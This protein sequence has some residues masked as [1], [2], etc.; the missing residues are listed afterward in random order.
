MEKLDQVKNE[1]ARL[2]DKL[3]AKREEIA[4]MNKDLDKYATTQ[5]EKLKAIQD[6]LVVVQPVLKAIA[7][8]MEN[9]EDG[10]VMDALAMLVSDGKRY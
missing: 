4:R 1:Q 9:S 7:A 10:D 6:S 5:I 8:L 2:E 3:K